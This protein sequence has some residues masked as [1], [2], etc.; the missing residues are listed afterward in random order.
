MPMNR[1]TF[2]STSTALT[3]TAIA[4]LA[5]PA[6][7]KGEQAG[8]EKN[9]VF[10]SLI[11]TANN[12]GRYAHKA[13]GHLPTITVANTPQGKII[14]VETNHE[15]NGFQHYI[16]KHQLFNQNFQLLGEHLFNPE[17]EHKPLSLFTLED[18]SGPL[19]AISMCN[20]HD[21]WMAQSTL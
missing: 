7:G 18:Y 16:V 10:G 17:V 21:I 3:S 15:M 6:F 20:K 8:L 1:R 2:L 4:L 12:P 9:A 11:F 19:Y 5:Q 13:K 14:R